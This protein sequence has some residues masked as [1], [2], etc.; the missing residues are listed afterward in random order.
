MNIPLLTP[1]GSRILHLV[2]L[3]LGFVVFPTGELSAASSAI[4]SFTASPSSIQ[5][6]QSAVLSW[7]VSGARSQSISPGLGSVTG[8]SATVKPNA[9]TTYTLT[10]K[11][12]KSSFTARTTVTVKPPPP[13]INTFTASP[14][15]ILNGSSTVLSWTSSG[16]N[17]LSISPSVGTVKGSSKTVSPATTTTYTLTASNA[18]GSVMS[19]TTVTVT[20]NASG[21]SYL[22]AYDTQLRGDWVASNWEN[23]PLAL[24][25][26]ATAPLVGG[27]AIEVGFTAN[28]SW[29]AFGLANR[30][31]GWDN[32]Y[33]YFNEF[34]TVEFDL[35]FAPDC[36]GASNLLFILEDAGYSDAPTL[37]SLIP[38]WATLSASARLGRWYHVAIKLADLHPNIP[39]FE[40]FLLFNNADSSNSKP[41]FFLANIKLGWAPDTTPPILSFQAATPGLNFNDLTLDF[42]T[43]EPTIWRVE[44]GAGNTN[45]ILTGDLNEWSTTHS[46]VLTGLQP[47]TTYNY[48]IVALDHRFLSSATPNQGTYTGSFAMPTTPTSPPIISGLSTTEVTAEHATLAWSTNRP[49]SAKVT[50]AKAGGTPL[51]REFTDFVSTRSIQLDLL[52]P[53]TTYTATVTT[54]DAFG[55]S[56]NA[57][58][59]FTSTQAASAS[60]T[61]SV[62]PGVTKPISP[63]IYGL[64][65]YNQING[66]ANNLTLDRTGGNRWTAYNWENNA[67]NA[68][69]DWGPYSNDSYLGGGEIPDEAVRS[70]VEADR[71]RG[72]ASLITVP[73]QGF[74]SADK[75]GLVS[76]SDSTRF[77]SRFRQLLFKKPAAL[78]FSTTPSLSDSVVY[79]DESLWALAKHIGSDIYTDPKMPTFV[80]LD[81]EPDLWNSTHAEIQSAAVSTSEL[82]QKTIALSTA[83]KQLNPAMVIFGPVNYGF[84]GLV[85]LQGN[86]GFS[87][88]YWFVDKYLAD[89][90][91]AETSAG[92]RL[93]DVYD[94]HWYSEAQGDG[95]RVVGLTGSAL[96]ANQV[97]AIVQSPRSLWDP[98]YTENSWV[99]DYLGGPVRILDRMQQKIDANYPGT[100]LAVT[101]YNHG[102]ENH[103]SGAIAEADTLGIFGARGVFAATYWP[104]TDSF[105]FVMAG[106]RMYRDYDGASS[107]FGDICLPTSSSDTAKVSAYVSRS[108][109]NSK[110]W[111]IVAINRST[112]NQSVAFNGLNAIGTAKVYRVQGT[113]PSP[114]LVG[115]VPV[116]LAN[117]VISLPALSVSTIEVTE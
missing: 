58:Y 29:N 40:Q 56:S 83:L 13:V 77:T 9:T 66:A 11:T 65:F 112:A 1:L 12:A 6:G 15:T 90:H 101:E 113:T 59:I 76:L 86:S 47:G 35:Y 28:N 78:P 52:E 4:N 97:Q 22:T 87:D 42:T 27:P 50:Y 92:L 85:N 5:A 57:Q 49:C 34:K 18:G 116:N 75:N 26:A 82:I 23:A 80:C 117:W 64:N 91:S 48:R 69:S 99:A 38:E 72:C 107:S 98:S 73:M 33:L 71:A 25:F 55:L 100:K 94:F 43:N 62:T 81:N 31:P 24:N 67:S 8:S 114:S 3:V 104:F 70:I 14:S 46:A 17:S 74:V 105:P 54:T 16:A 36:T 45:S 110:R 95:Q 63:W 103:I 44:Y 53:A 21:L 68:G 2:I 10:V 93:L 89:L 37:V 109:S 7:N 32:Q 79:V 20:P 19:S 30:K 51:S 96:S 41:H 106:L 108:S 39:R 88:T 115:Q 111:V 60:I 84:G 102:G 61:I